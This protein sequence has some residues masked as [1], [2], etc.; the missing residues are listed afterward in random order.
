[1]IA[2]S[3][4]SAAT[5]LGSRPRIR[6]IVALT[7][8]IAAFAGIP[9]AQDAAW[10]HSQATDPRRGAYDEFTLVGKYVTLPVHPASGP[11]SLQVTCSGGKFFS[12]EFRTQIAVQTQP[13]ARSF[14]GNP[15]ARVIIRRVSYGVKPDNDWWE[16]DKNGQ[17]LYF[18]TRQFD[19][20]LT[21][22]RIG[23]PQDPKSLLHNVVLGVT[24][25][26]DNPVVVRFDMPDDMTE[27]L[28]ACGWKKRKK[29]R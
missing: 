20:L 2:A 3:N 22:N 4:R 11:P 14:R 17:T 6:C 27:M 24:E 9:F 18:D 8:A 13:G 15:Q 7:G 5:R 28:E 29:E 26:F 10:K 23:T 16:L 25:L 21:G 19:K 1:M 12:G